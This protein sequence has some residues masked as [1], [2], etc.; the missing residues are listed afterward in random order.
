MTDKKICTRCIMDTSAPDIE[1]DESGVCN[2]CK[3]YEERAKNE[4]LDSITKKDKLSK[5]LSIIKEDGKEKENDCIIGVSGGIDSTYTAFLTKE[6]GLRPLAIHLDNGWDSELSVSNIEKTLNVLGID[7]YTHVIDWEEFK[8]LQLSFLKSSITNIEI[9]TD[10]AITAILYK[11]A[12]EE[13]INYIISGNNIVT[14]SIQPSYWGEYNKD[15]KLLESI[16]KRFGTIDLKTFPRI[17]LKRFAYYTLIKHI[18]HISLLD[19]VD[20]NKEEAKKTLQNKLCWIDYGGKHYES[21]FTRFFQGYIL[22]KKYNVDKRL[23]HLSTLIMSGQITREEALE[24]MKLPVYPENLFLEDK[25][26]VL[27]KLGLTE[28][29][30]EDIMNLPIKSDKDYP[31]NSWIFENLSFLVNA[32]KRFAK[33]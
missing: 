17:S 23:G 27:K 11:Q 29:D 8:D 15:L 10:H 25:E 13:N 31:S 9:P 2:Y 7:L 22:I 4:L 26:F 5:I 20:Y 18:K 24:E 16:H 6:F 28:K 12:A 3:A 33:S 14:E 19:Y 30:F 21:I 32:A 1:F